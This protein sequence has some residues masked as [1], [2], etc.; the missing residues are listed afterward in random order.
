MAHILLCGL[1]IAP[2]SKEGADGADVLTGCWNL[3]RAFHIG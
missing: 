3:I 1:A 2:Y